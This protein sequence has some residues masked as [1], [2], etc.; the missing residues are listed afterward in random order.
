MGM[1]GRVSLKWSGMSALNPSTIKLS[2]MVTAAA[3]LRKFQGMDIIT[4]VGEAIE[5]TREEAIRLNREQLYQKGIKADGTRMA[6]YKNAAYARKK[7]ARN[8][9]PG[10]GNPDA[11]ATGDMQKGIFVDV[12]GDKA[13]FDSISPHATFMIQRDGPAIFGLTDESKSV[14]QIVLMPE[15]VR[16]IKQI[17][18]TI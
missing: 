11:Y 2:H 16:R 17:T 3:M 12:Q 7:Y 8:P 9:G 10:Y 4:V 1:V 6:P 15:T 5:A 18:G 13:V 14:Y